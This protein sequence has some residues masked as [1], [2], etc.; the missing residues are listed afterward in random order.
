MSKLLGIPENQ[1]HPVK[2]YNHEIVSDERIDV[3]ALMALRQILYSAEDHLDNAKIREAIS[4]TCVGNTDN[5]QGRRRMDVESAS[6][7]I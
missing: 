6:E 1:I 3:L 4:V 5:V 7:A 2:C